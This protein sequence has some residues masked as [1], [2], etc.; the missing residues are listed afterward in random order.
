MDAKFVSIN[1]TGDLMPWY[2]SMMRFLNSQISSRVGGVSKCPQLAQFRLIFWVVS[3]YYLVD[4]F[5]R[6]TW[7]NMVFSL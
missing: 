3:F 5:G 2:V 7:K 6:R 4:F 1:F